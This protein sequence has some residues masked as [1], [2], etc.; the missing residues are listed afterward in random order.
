MMGSTYGV[1]LV[2]SEMRRRYFGSFPLAAYNYPLTVLRVKPAARSI[3]DNVS[4]SQ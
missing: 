4:P 2:L 1:I 3:S